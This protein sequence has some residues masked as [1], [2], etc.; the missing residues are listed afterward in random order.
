MTAAGVARVLA[1]TRSVVGAALLARPMAIA[2]PACRGRREPAAWVVRLLGGRML[3]QGVFELLRPRP[4]VFLAG[5]AVDGS[6]ALSMLG[7]AAASNG[8][9]PVALAS[10]GTAAASGVGAALAAEALRSSTP[11]RN[12]P[13]AAKQGRAGSAS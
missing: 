3:A 10:A 12:V 6:H 7:L 4:D 5:A 9:R 2:R 13:A 11:L 8:F 1:A